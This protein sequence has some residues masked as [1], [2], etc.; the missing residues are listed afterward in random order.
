K[1]TNGQLVER[2][3][4]LVETLGSKVATPDDARAILNLKP[5]S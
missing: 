2:A 5:R 4:T 1:A 3:G